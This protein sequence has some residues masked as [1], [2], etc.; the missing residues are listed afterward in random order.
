[1]AWWMEITTKYDLRPSLNIIT[2]NFI[3][4]GFGRVCAS[5]ERNTRLAQIVA[6]SLFISFVFVELN[7]ICQ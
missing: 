6:N 1:M 2:T 4:V 3:L 5:F 7:I